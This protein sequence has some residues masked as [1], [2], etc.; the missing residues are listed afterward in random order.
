MTKHHMGL[1]VPELQ[2]TTNIL[3]EID[4]FQPTELQ[5]W[6]GREGRTE[7][8]INGNNTVPLAEII[9]RASRGSPQMVQ[10]YTVT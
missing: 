10:I 4:L 1:C 8:E 3:Q 6:G 7:A 9:S 5:E 2:V